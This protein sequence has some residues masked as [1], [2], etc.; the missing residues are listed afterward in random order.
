MCE[1]KCHVITI[2]YITF[3]LDKSKQGEQTE[4]VHLT[5]RELCRK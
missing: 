3:F 1:S 2:E 5:E 4:H